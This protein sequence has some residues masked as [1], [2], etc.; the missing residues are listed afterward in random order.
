MSEAIYKAPEAN[1]ARDAVNPLN[2]LEYHQLWLLVSGRR[3][4]LLL[5]AFLCFSVAVCVFAIVLG[6]TG[7]IYLDAITFWTLVYGAV[8]N[9]GFAYAMYSSNKWGLFLGAIGA[10]VALFAVPVGTVLGL[11]GLHGFYQARAIY[12]NRDYS[13]AGLRQAYKKYR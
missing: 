6:L 1:L 11:L 5:F 13:F 12:L 7:L 10:V 2:E 8:L 3:K 4:I 9:G